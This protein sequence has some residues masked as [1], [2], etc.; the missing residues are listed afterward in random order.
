MHRHSTIYVI[1][2]CGLIFVNFALFFFVF[3]SFP[4]RTE[5]VSLARIVA[6]KA[7]LRLNH[8]PRGVFLYVC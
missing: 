7:G 4:A 8:A 3:N 1:I 2:L 6:V 5:L